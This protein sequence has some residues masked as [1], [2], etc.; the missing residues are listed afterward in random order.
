MMR[1][2]TDGRGLGMFF[3]LAFGISWAAW[4]AG[5]FL[6]PGS[7]G[8]L[9]VLGGFGPAI[10]AV[11]VSLPFGGG[12]SGGLIR[13]IVHWRAPASLYVFALLMPPLLYSIAAAVLHLLVELRVPAGVPSILAYPTALLGAALF[14]GGQ[15]EVGWRGFA[16]PR[17]QEAL[18]PL[19]ASLL[20][21]FLWALWYLPL[22]FIPGVPHLGM[23]ILPYVAIVVG[24]SVILTWLYN[25]SGGSVPVA[26][27]F[28][29]G[30]ILAR[31]WYPSDLCLGFTSSGAII[32][33][34]V[35]ATAG[36]LVWRSGEGLGL[37]G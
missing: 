8:L 7:A 26:V 36:V 22:F 20:L 25:A 3:L 17:L 11:T 10:A 1:S 33:L 32:V 9:V 2:S 5:G 27:L 18:A 4:F 14:G 13:R 24:F 23:P 15:S 21:G 30:A 31:G 19:D 37:A 12:G 34:V 35:W 16:L 29:A 28:H 6:F